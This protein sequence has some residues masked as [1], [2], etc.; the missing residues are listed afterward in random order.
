[1]RFKVISRVAVFGDAALVI[2]RERRDR[3]TL[4]LYDLFAA[5]SVDLSSGDTRELGTFAMW[6]FLRW[7]R[8]VD[9]NPRDALFRYDSCSECEAQTFLA[10]FTVDPE[11]RAWRVSDWPGVG[12]RILVR[13]DHEPDDE[14]YRRCVFG[15]GRY[16]RGPL[17]SLAVWCREVEVKTDGVK[18][19]TLATYSGSGGELGRTTL[20][21]VEA[22]RVKERL[23]IANQR[24][25][26]CR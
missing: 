11:T 17:D 10:S 13:S 23:C 5:Y 26:L 16:A 12:P 21:G 4:S 20:A 3:K 2:V 8:F 7:S 25:S 1:L 19:E 9:R 22:R 18:N 6:K 15:V 24:S 14:T